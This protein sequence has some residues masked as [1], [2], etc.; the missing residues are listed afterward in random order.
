MA[1]PTL[2]EQYGRCQHNDNDQR[3]GRDPK[4]SQKERDPA[5]ADVLL[6]AW[7]AVNY[8]CERK[9]VQS[10]LRISMSHGAQPSAIGATRASRVWKHAFGAGPTK[11]ND[12]INL[13]AT[14]GATVVR[15]HVLHFIH[16]LRCDVGRDL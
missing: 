13:L 5:K 1:R 16:S 12:I 15:I 3:R 2:H 14:S 4:T 8:V 7:R 11:S 10:Q 9:V 6:K